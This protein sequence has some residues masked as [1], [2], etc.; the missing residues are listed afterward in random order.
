[1]FG[2]TKGAREYLEG[3]IEGYYP[4]N[5]FIPV[6]KIYI[7]NMFRVNPFLNVDALIIGAGIRFFKFDIGITH[8]INVSSLHYAT[9]FNGA[10]EISLIYTGGGNKPKNIVE[11]C[12]IY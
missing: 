4:E 5:L 3:G 12:F 6:K 11:P 9:N 10:F 1:M 2:Y 8:D 7:I